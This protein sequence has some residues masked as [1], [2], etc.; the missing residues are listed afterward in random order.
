MARPTSG[1]RRDTDLL[2]VL[3]GREARTRGGL[4]VTRIAELAGREK[5]QVSRALASLSEEGLVD[6]DPDT[7][8]YRLGWRLYAL[9]ARTGEARLAYVSASFL[10]RLV[11]Q[12]H[13]TVHLCVLRGNGVLTLVSESSPN[14]FRSLGWEG[15]M[16]PALHTS[17]GRVLVS[18]WEE[19]VLRAW[20]P[21]EQF[22]GMPASQRIRTIDDLLEEIQAIRSCGYAMADEEFEA[23][24]V[25]VSAPVRDHGGRVIAAI[26]MG[27][28]K[29]RMGQRLDAAGRLTARC[30]LELS[31]A[32]GYESGSGPAGTSAGAPL[33]PLRPGVQQPGTAARSAR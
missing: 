17:A 20:F 27:A 18:D 3:A 23:G 6:R 16:V 21:E 30:A 4:G 10:R 31:R 1:L 8:A 28:P 12:L 11:A 19:P 7:Q 15:V 14:A 25:G 2:E 13:E 5:S 26:N 29:G 9:A 33:P 24:L 32:L 22:A